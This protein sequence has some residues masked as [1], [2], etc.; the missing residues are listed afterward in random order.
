LFSQ[1]G[2]LF[3]LSRLVDCGKALCR[4]IVNLAKSKAIQNARRYPHTSAHSLHVAPR[5]NFFKK[6]GR[7]DD[8][9]DV[10]MSQL[11]AVQVK[12]NLVIRAE[13]LAIL[14]TK[15]E[16]GM[17]MSLKTRLFIRVSKSFEDRLWNLFCTRQGS[18]L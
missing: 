4:A 9:T 8:P 2:I 3:H 17:R 15:S 7:L 1:I 13:T 10:W 18:N 5:P 16:D 11:V 14:N 6:S 12:L